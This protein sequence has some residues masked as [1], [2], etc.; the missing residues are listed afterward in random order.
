MNTKKLTFFF[1][2]AL[3]V[4]L[5]PGEVLSQSCEDCISGPVSFNVTVNG[6]TI[7]V[8]NTSNQSP[9]CT[10]QALWDFGD[11]NGAS[12][13]GTYQHTYSQSGTYTV[14]LT[15]VS[16][17]P[18][19]EDCS[20]TYCQTITVNCG[21]CECLS[22]TNLFSY[23][24][25]GCTFTFNELISNNPLCPFIVNKPL[26]TLKWT[27]GDGD[28]GVG[29]NPQH[30]YN[31]SGTYTVCL[32]YTVYNINTGVFCTDSVC[33]QIS[34]NCSPC[35][36]D[37]ITN[38]TITAFPNSLD[39]STWSFFYTDKR[40]LDSCLTSVIRKWSFGDGTMWV[41]LSSVIP[42]HTYS[43][44]GRYKVCVTDYNLLPNGDTCTTTYCDS[45]DINI[46]A[47]NLPNSS[48]HLGLNNT[49]GKTSSTSRE[50]EAYPNPSKGLV[51]FHIPNI[52]LS[53]DAVLEI[54]DLSG[55]LLKQ[56]PVSANSILKVNFR[57]IGTG[58]LT[59]S[60]KSGG[61]QIARKKILIE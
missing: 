43:A 19:G 54:K 50:L 3:S 5:S 15:I 11:S 17:L 16:K 41:G 1:L 31:G 56:I 45:I 38:Q 33:Q 9:L 29:S 35:S 44:S 39:S 46:G 18:T 34:V 13:T 2:L 25:N 49:S 42:S 61:V 47:G 23:S 53:Q 10:Y 59:C 57:A 26:T 14:C 58:I 7:D 20:E 28:T 22:S 27:F 55:R 40:P 51:N 4:W 6:C 36:C 60:L 32:T 48:N 12:G 30:T 52:S 37:S 21:G 8:S 24:V